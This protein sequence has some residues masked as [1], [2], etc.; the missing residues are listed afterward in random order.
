V[1]HFLIG[2]AAA[3]SVALAATPA[4]AQLSDEKP[5][6]GGLARFF[7]EPRVGA[8]LFAN[9]GMRDFY[10]AG[11]FYAG[12]R[13]GLTLKPGSLVIWPGRRLPGTLSLAAEGGVSWDKGRDTFPPNEELELLQAPFSTGLEWAPFR[14]RE[15]MLLVPFVGGG[16]GGSF[17]REKAKVTPALITDGIRWGW[18]AEGG[19]RFL[20][21]YWDRSAARSFERNEGIRNTWIGLRGRYQRLRMFD[22]G[23]DLSNFT[24]DL[25]MQFEM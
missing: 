6:Q 25:S 5:W 18:N 10:D 3:L 21:D 9:K 19:V 14:G 20:M 2:A 17:F 8:L 7:F 22:P 23:L 16:F 13:A 11:N 12:L 1:K 24:V 15:E 4:R